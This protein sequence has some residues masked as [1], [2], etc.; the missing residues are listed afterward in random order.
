[1]NVILVALDIFRCFETAVT[2]RAV[3]WVGV[4]LFVA[5]WEGVSAG[6][7][8]R[9]RVV[10]VLQR[11]RRRKDVLIFVSMGECSITILEFAENERGVA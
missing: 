4:G 2:D 10:G 1:M 8:K 9:Y 11:K 5:A 6:N 7:L 3:C